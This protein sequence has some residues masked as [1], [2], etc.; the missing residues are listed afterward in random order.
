MD[1]GLTIADSFIAPAECFVCGDAEDEAYIFRLERP[2][3]VLVLTVCASCKL[4]GE[5]SG[6]SE[7]AARVTMSRMDELAG[8]WVRGRDSGRA[9]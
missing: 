6:W 2:R 7:K 4:T 9:R 5:R 8:D 3:W 1:S